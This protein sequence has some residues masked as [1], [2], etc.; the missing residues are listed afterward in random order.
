MAEGNLPEAEQCYRRARDMF[1]A[2]NPT[3]QSVTATTL[4]LGRLLIQQRRYGNATYVL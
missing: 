1:I 2:D 4:A 3:Q